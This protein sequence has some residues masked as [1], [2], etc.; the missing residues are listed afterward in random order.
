MQLAEN[1]AVYKRDDGIVV[2][3]PVKAV[4]QKQI[5]GTCPHRMI[6]WNEEKQLPQKCDL[7]A[8]F[9]DQ[10][11]TKPRCVE[12]CPTG[13]LIFGDLSDPQSEISKLVA[14]KKPVPVQSGFDLDESVLYVNIPKKFVTGTVIYSDTD[15]CAKGATVTLNGDS[16]SLS[17]E[18]DAFGDFW[19]D[20]L[21]SRKDFTLEIKA[22]GY[23][24]I[25]LAAR[26]LSD[27]NLGNIALEK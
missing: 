16:I 25:S 15:Q 10:G 20:G 3:D 4:G 14:E 8:H 21:E 24:T 18:T 1:D 12:M 6:F 7:C 11:F 17:A 2:I 23:R 13:A 19:F 9:L 27:V 26:T 5:V 22:K